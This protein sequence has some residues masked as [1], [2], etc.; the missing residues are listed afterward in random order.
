[1]FS[2]TDTAIARDSATERARVESGCE[3]GKVLSIKLNQ[4]ETPRGGRYNI[5]IIRAHAYSLYKYIYESSDNGNVYC[6]R[7]D[8]GEGTAG[9]GTP[10]ETTHA[11]TN[12][13]FQFVEQLFE[14]G[15]MSIIYTFYAFIYY[16]ILRYR[17]KI[18]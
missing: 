1:M 17:N 18:T 10:D 4:T 5:Y 12:I 7:G 6:S 3:T 14:I 9:T 11:G 16:N 13:I 15:E 2:F 8:V